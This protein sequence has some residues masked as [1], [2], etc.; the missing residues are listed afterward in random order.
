[1]TKKYGLSFISD[2][3]LYAH[4]RETIEKYRFK[5]NLKQFNKNLIDPVKLTFDAK[6]MVRLLKKSLKQSLSD[7]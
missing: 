4:V 3:Q 6:F 2:E 7:K 1:M 5:I